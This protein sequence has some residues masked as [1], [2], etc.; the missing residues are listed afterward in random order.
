MKQGIAFRHL[1]LMGSAIILTGGCNHKPK[2]PTER[3]QLK[4]G[5]YWIK[6]PNNESITITYT[7]GKVSIDFVDDKGSAF[8]YSSNV[9][10]DR[11]GRIMV[12]DNGA[13]DVVKFDPQAKSPD[14]Q[15]PPQTKPK[16]D[17]PHP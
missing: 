4:Q 2:F 11:P 7:T 9:A 17:P 3:I 16:S 14:E 6:G 8:S 13:T 12:I 1:I 10:P 15:L 5:S